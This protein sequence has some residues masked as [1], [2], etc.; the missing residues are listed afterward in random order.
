[1]LQ[2]GLA[3]QERVEVGHHHRDAQGPVKMNLVSM[4]MVSASHPQIIARSVYSRSQARQ[5]WCQRSA[6]SLR[7]FIPT[8]RAPGSWSRSS[9]TAR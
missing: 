2:R 6:D 4:E 3:H 5:G 9:R 7:Q 1:M 8:A